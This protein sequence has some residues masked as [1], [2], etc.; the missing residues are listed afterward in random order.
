MIYTIQLPADHLQ[1]IANILQNTPLPYAQVAPVLDNLRQQVDAQNAADQ[2][3]KA[4]LTPSEL[5]D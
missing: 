5:G 2:D 3:E 1:Y 4:G